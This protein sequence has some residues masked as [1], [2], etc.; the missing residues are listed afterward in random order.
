LSTSSFADSANQNVYEMGSRLFGAQRVAV[1]DAYFLMDSTHSS[2]VIDSFG[3]MGFRF[4]AQTTLV[5]LTDEWVASLAARGCLSILVGVENFFSQETGKPVSAEY[6]EDR[7]QLTRKYGIRL[8]P[9]FICGFSDVDFDHDRRQLDYVRSLIERRLVANHGVQ[10]NLYMPYIADPADRLIG[11]PF[12]FWGVLP[13]APRSR[14][15]W[16]QQLALCD[17]I[18]ETI[19]GEHLENY[20][21]V[22]AEYMFA[23]EECGGVPDDIPNMSWMPADR[24]C[25]LVAR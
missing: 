20:R 13:V 12:R 19:Y 2:E 10:V 25:Q 3:D 6:L 1:P 24:R 18:Y 22:R 14:L 5:S 21:A 16:E 8:F 7:I 4:A 23:V 11:V 15:H 17:E 9:T